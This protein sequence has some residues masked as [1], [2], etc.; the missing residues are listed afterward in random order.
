MFA[1]L[2][3]GMQI[4]GMEALE[5]YGVPYSRD[6]DRHTATLDSK[7]LSRLSAFF[8]HYVVPA[9][10]D[11]EGTPITYSACSAL[12][13]IHGL[14]DHA[15]DLGTSVE[16]ETGAEYVDPYNLTPSEP[17]LLINRQDQ[18]ASGVTG[19]SNPNYGL[20]V[21]DRCDPELNDYNWQGGLVIARNREIMDYAGAVQLEH[22]VR[23]E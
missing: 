10:D 3:I 17:Y 16:Y 9:F 2:V 4:P 19:Y 8:K 5:I 12:D 20:T 23:S 21:L 6:T 1:R 18:I 22:L 15:D 14:A 7:V 13:Y 11:I